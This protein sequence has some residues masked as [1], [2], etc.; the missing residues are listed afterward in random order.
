MKKVFSWV[1]VIVVV[2]LMFAGC[3]TGNEGG[4]TVSVLA[5]ESVEFQK[6]DFDL[7]PMFAPRDMPEGNKAFTVSLAYSDTGDVSKALSA[8]FNNGHFLVNDTEVKIGSTS[9]S[10]EE[11]FVTLHSSRNPDG[12]DDSLSIKLVYNGNILVIK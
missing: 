2:T 4:K 7:S 9:H 12:S 8:I 1:L 11:K 5:V 6:R 10:E 3:S